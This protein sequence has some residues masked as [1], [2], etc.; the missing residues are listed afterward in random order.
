M[1]TKR[2]CIHSLGC[3]RTLRPSRSDLW[4]EAAYTV[5]TVLLGVTLLV[6]CRFLEISAREEKASQTLR[7]LQKEIKL[8][9][10]DRER[11]VTVR[12]ETIQKLRCCQVNVMAAAGSNSIASQ[13]LHAQQLAACDAGHAI[14]E[15]C[16]RLD[17]I[18]GCLAIDHAVGVGITRQ[19]GTRLPVAALL[20]RRDELEEIKTST[21][22]ETKTLQSDTKTQEES[23][24]S[25]FQAASSL[26]S[27]R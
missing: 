24:L 13:L 12:N 8:E 3:V 2:N 22:N 23:D 20:P 16:L 17:H 5:P 25:N 11:Q 21:I 27:N 14:L 18:R 7:Q 6:W 1:C 4:V 26:P 9:K 15:Y 10:A 19:T